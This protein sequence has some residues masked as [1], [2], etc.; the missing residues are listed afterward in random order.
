MDN[1][2]IL[3]PGE[4]LD[5]LDY[6]GMVLIQKENSFR[7]GTDSVLLAGFA[8]VSSRE[9]CIDLGAGSGVLSV[10]LHARTNCHMFAVEVD[11]QQCEM[12]NRTIRINEIEKYIEVCNKNYITD[13]DCIGRGRFDAAI[14]N[15]PYHRL[16]CGKLSDNSGAT[17]EVLADIF[18]VALSASALLKFG[19]KF[20]MCFP[21]ERLSE[22]FC[23]LSEAVLEP[24]RLRLVCSK[25]S[26][27][28]YLC[29]IEAK[30]GGKP[31]LIIENS[32][33]V[34][35]E[36]GEYTD[37]VKRIYHIDI[38]EGRMG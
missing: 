20:F 4:R 15:P 23:A 17:H 30:K 18:R 12:L 29:L 10:L 36:N 25:P 13:L 19:G 27:R 32:L 26:K 31:G 35:N 21:S 33:I 6:R 34:C 24:K 16:N 28:P 2:N 37:E 7:F 22:A 14:C 8:K 1:S 38:D 5:L 3:L 9:S 11:E